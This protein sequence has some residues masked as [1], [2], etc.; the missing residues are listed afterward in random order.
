MPIGYAAVGLRS[1]PGALTRIRTSW[2]WMMLVALV[3]ATAPAHALL[4]I[5]DWKTSSGAR[6]LFV[7]NHDLAML[8]V[9][10]DFPAGSGHDTKAKAGRAAFTQQ[11]LKL[12]AGGLSE[13][14]ISQRIADVGANLGGRFDS[15]RAGVYLRTLSSANER[16]RAL[17]VMAKVLLQPEFPEPVL[18]RE[19]ARA[20]AGLKEADTKPD[21]LA[22]RAFARAVYADHPYGLRAS[23]EVETLTTLTRADLADFYRR[24]YVAERAIV[25]IMGDVTRADAQKIAEQLTAGLPRAGT[26]PIAIPQVQDLAQPSAT[27]IAHPASQSHIL[28]GA[29]GIRRGDPDYFPLFVGNY[30][31][32]GGGFESR[33]TD[34]VRQKRGLAYSVY[35]YFAPLLREGPFQIGLQTRGDQAKAAIEVVMQTLREFVAKGPSE[36]ELDDAKKNLT[37]GFPLRI[38]S[39]RK[40][41]EYLA[42]IGFYDMPLTYLEDFV[43][44]IRKVGITDIKAAFARHVDPAKLATVVVGGGVA[45]D[46]ER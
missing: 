11:L 35:S 39:N 3:L 27:R 16:D 32:G 46:A 1:R 36:Q 40:I 4:P 22:N 31:L 15:D 23:G 42:T 30:I 44:N 28:I 38:D 26:E 19:R 7:E 5:Q 21:T 33:L 14:E 34:E 10:V 17:D 13:N 43:P 2:A 20:I 24:H 45:T 12:G 18:A 37:G 9:S 8:D 6:V 41:H 29:P 25:A